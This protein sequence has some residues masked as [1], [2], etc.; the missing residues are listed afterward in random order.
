MN[1]EAGANASSE[2]S[3]LHERGL[4]PVIEAYKQHIDRTLLRE[5]LHKT[6]EQ[7]V[8]TLMALQRLAA[9]ARRAGRSAG[10]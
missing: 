4:D 9:E 2:R 1:S 10:K 7:R 8:R 6:P 5:N 3:P